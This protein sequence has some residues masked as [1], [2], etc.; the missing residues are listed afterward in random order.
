MDRLLHDE[1][2]KSKLLIITEAFPFGHGEPFLIA[3]LPYL[4]EQFS[5]T[6][7][8]L[9][10]TSPLEKGIDASVSIERMNVK[11]TVFERFAYLIAYFLN[12]VCRKEFQNILQSNEKIIRRFLQSIAMYS[13][14]AKW[15]HKLEKFSWFQEQDI[16][17]SY[18]YNDKLIGSVLGL[19]K[20][21]KKPVIVSRIHG[22]DLFNE[23]KLSGRQPFKPLVDEYL[24][25]LIWPFAVYSG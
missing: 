3:E 4:C 22:Y 11:L 23:R 12:S 25:Q 19:R 15:F 21:Q 20:A 16:I 1:T 13:S 5:V 2:H 8:S 17:Y 24:H 9:D 14:G 6:I 10:T 7:V 18:W